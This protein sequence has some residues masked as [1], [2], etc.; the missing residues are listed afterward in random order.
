MAL[1]LYAVETPSLLPPMALSCHQGAFA[2]VKL[3]DVLWGVY[4]RGHL[5]CPWVAM[6]AGVPGMGEGL[7]WRATGNSCL[8]TSAPH[9]GPE[10]C[11]PWCPHCPQE[12]GDVGGDGCLVDDS[13]P[14]S[15]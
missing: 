3:E 8:P 11:C 1:S 6:M 13:C 14:F 5:P 2:L 9:I 7:T 12:A 4:W 15:N 10:P